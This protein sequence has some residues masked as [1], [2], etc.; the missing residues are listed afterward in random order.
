LSW[1]SRPRQIAAIVC[2]LLALVALVVEAT[3]EF[4]ILIAASLALWAFDLRERK[5]VGR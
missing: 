2:V 5:R 1:I 3:V 4:W